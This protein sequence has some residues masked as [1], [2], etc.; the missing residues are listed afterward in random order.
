M[1][2]DELIEN[3]IDSIKEENYILEKIGEIKDERVRNIVLELHNSPQDKVMELHDNH[4][5]KAGEE[6]GC[7]TCWI[8]SEYEA[9][10]N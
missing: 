6:S 9:L 1:T 7:E 10:I 8:Y 4:D 2:H 3:E 5:C